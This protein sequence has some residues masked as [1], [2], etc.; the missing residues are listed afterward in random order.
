MTDRETALSYLSEG[1]ALLRANGLYGPSDDKHV[2]AMDRALANF[3]DA[4]A[5]GA[6]EAAAA[7]QALFEAKMLITARSSI[8]GIRIILG[9]WFI[10]LSVE[11][12]LPLRNPLLIRMISEELR[13]MGIDANRPTFKVSKKAFCA[14][15]DRFTNALTDASKPR[16]EEGGTGPATQSGSGVIHSEAEASFV[17]RVGDFKNKQKNKLLAA[18]G[19]GHYKAS[20]AETRAALAQMEY[21]FAQKYAAKGASEMDGWIYGAIMSGG[22]RL[23][24]MLVSICSRLGNGA[25]AD[26]VINI[27]STIELM[28][29]ASLVHDDIVDRSPLRRSRATINAEKGD[30]Y[31]AMCGFKMISDALGMIADGCAD[32]MAKTLASIPKKMCGGELRQF[33]IENKPAL[34]SEDEYYR[35]IECKTAALIEGSCACGAILGGADERVA[36]ILADYGRSLGILFQLR[37]DLLDYTAADRTNTDRGKDISGKPVSQDMERGIYSL[38]LLY[39]KEKLV[40]EN[41]AEAKKLDSVLKKHIKS[42]ADFRYLNDIAESSGGLDYAMEAICCY[43]DK[44]VAKLE[45]LPQGP[46]TESLAMLVEALA[47]TDSEGPSL[48]SIPADM[49]IVRLPAYE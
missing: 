19:E 14:T 38:P 23:R 37:D 31:A 42:A 7:I 35:R 1:Y 40:A 24:P 20:A 25:D 43:R 2:F 48:A 36:R 4:G 9:D 26:S 33:E 30:G 39:A 6:A 18:L 11:L 8:E 5:A 22:K 41:P 49:K 27:M 47:A 46:Y 17:P 13:G 34:Q 28:H 12:A 45:L 32:N 15:I 3:A 16:G 29:S 10:S 21:R 44:A